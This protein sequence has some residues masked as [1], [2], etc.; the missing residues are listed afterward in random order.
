MDTYI[1]NSSGTLIACHSY[2]YVGKWKHKW[3]YIDCYSL[4]HNVDLNRFLGTFIHNQDI[5]LLFSIAGLSDC[6]FFCCHEEFFVADITERKTYK[7]PEYIKD[8]LDRLLCSSLFNFDPVGYMN[9]MKS[10]SGGSD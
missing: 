2:D 1:A 3:P 6:I 8:H 9:K 7:Y 4:T 10:L 5:E